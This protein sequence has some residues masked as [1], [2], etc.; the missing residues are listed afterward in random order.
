MLYRWTKKIHMYSGLLSFL[1]L[2]VWGVVG[3]ES[4]FRSAPEDR[5]RV[6]PAVR[7]L[8]F[9]APDDI[10]D[11]ELA[12]AM[13]DAAK[14]P[15]IT[16]APRHRR[17]EQNLLSMN[18]FTVNGRRR[19][20][21]LEDESKIRIEEFPATA[22]GFLDSAH[23]NTIFHSRPAWQLKLWGA[24]NETSL[25]S[26][27][28]MTLSGIYLWLATRPKLAWAGWTLGAGCAAFVLFY[29]AVR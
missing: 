14:M 9:E 22:W 18:Y 21:L 4:A 15:F 11:P 16:A 28:F 20:T 6:E 7:Y 26:V 27:T 29:A 25:W 1:G 3:V 24:Y 17:D 13:V 10:A 2:T 8:A 12:Q 19:L 23:V 5:P